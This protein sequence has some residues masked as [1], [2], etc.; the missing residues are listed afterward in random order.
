MESVPHQQLEF[1]P[2]FQETG[3]DLPDHLKDLNDRSVE[4]LSYR[5]RPQF[6]EI[7]SEFRD[8]F[9]RGSQDLERTALAKHE[10]DKGAAAPL[11]PP[12]PPPRRLLLAQREQA[13]KAVEEMHQQGIIEPS[14]SRHQ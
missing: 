13:R 14:N 12:P 1:G 10:I 4:G 5:Q 6:L 7:L 2:E 11:H 8:I 9:S 3:D